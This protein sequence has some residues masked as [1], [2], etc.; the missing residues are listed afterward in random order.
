MLQFA[1]SFEAGV[2]GL[3]STSVLLAMP[4]EKVAT[5]LRQNDD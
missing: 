3:R 1:R 2:E 5:G 4:L